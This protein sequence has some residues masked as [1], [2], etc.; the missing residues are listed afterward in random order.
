M[1]PLIEFSLGYVEVPVF[2]VITVFI[3]II[4]DIIRFV[5]RYWK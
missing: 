4:I 3:V 5:E 1:K 2:F